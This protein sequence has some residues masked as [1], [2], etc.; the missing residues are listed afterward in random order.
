MNKIIYYLLLFGGIYGIGYLTTEEQ[1]I[2]FIN[3][4]GGIKR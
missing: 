4:Y 3:T 2:N 1:C